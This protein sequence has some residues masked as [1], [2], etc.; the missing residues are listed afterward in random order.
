MQA[1]DFIRRD[2]SYSMAIDTDCMET[3]TEVVS[4]DTAITAAN[5]TTVTSKVTMSME[6]DCLGSTKATDT[7]S[8]GTMTGST[9]TESWKS[10]GSNSVTEDNRCKDSTSFDFA[11]TDIKGSTASTDCCSVRTKIKT[12]AGT[13]SL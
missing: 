4:F 12:A 3:T 1:I 13:V 5:T 7:E 6:T 10:M 8:M 2:F 9:K 11:K